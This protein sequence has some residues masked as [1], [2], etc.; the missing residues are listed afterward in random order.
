MPNIKNHPIAD[1]QL[2]IVPKNDNQAEKTQTDTKEYFGLGIAKIIV[3]VETQEIDPATGDLRH[4][5]ITNENS[6]LNESRVAVEAK[7]IYCL[8]TQKHHP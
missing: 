3:G 7:E 2:R 4:E 6:G 5:I 1:N 8:K